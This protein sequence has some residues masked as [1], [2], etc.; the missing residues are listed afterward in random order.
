MAKKKSAKR[1]ARTAKSL[2]R[3]MCGTMQVHQWL[4]ESDPTFRTN[5]LA[6]EH[7]FRARR[8]MAMPLRTTPYKIDVVVHVVYKT[9]AQ[10]IS[11]AQVN[12]Q[13]RVL[14]KDFRAKNSDRVKTPAAWKGLVSDP[15]I[16]FS[17]AKK[18]PRGQPT[19][20]ITRTQTNVD[21]FE[22]DDRVKFSQSGGADAWPTNKY[23]N[24]WVCQLNGGL[25]GYAQFPGGPADSDGVVILHTAFGTGGTTRV[26]FNQGRTTTHEI[27]HYLNLRHIWAD[28][29]DCG[30]SDF[31]ADTPNAETPNYGKPTFPHI[32]CQNGPHGD[33]FMNY[34][35]YV[36]DEAMFMFTTGQVDRMRM[37]LD[38]PRKGL[39]T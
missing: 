20:G 14:N 2:P 5:Q 27:G 19:T 31:V 18:D 33:M 21:G 15:M 6:I 36:D 39:V 7:A 9:A 11:A 34:M 26:P 25:L 30:G 1:K 3:R 23:L 37:T 12:S 22:D 16:E 35:D 10:N 32:S 13:I 8:G 4:L 29:E 24:I 28:T 17:L 38:G